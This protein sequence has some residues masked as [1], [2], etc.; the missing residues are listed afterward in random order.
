MESPMFVARSVM[1]PISRQ[2]LRLLVALALG[3]AGFSPSLAV[4]QPAKP[5]TNART[6]QADAAFTRGKD[7]MAAEKFAEA[8]VAFEESQRIDPR[9]PTLM[10]HANCR[11]K[12]AQLATASRLFS[13]VVEQLR[14][15][16]D[17][18]SLALR[19]VSSDRVA[20]LAPRLSYLT[21]KVTGS[22]AG[23][24][25]RR[26]DA[27]LPAAQ[28][29]QA[30]PVD[31]GTYLLT[32]SAPGQQ[33]W[34]ST[35]TVRPEGDKQTV[36]VPAL[37]AEPSSSAPIVEV[38]DP[39]TAS[40]TRKPSLYWMAL[41]VAAGVASVVLGV[42]ALGHYGDA[43]DLHDRDLEARNPD[44]SESPLSEALWYASN[45]EM[46][47][48][49]TWGIA[50]GVTA[51]VGVGLGIGLYVLRHRDAKESSSATARAPTFSPLLQPDRAGGGV[52]G[53]QL[54]GGW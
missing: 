3:V 12:N 50:S 17:P 35:I 27:L 30:V 33:P 18:D 29:N 6:A 22:P 14:N 11:E 43:N 54:T 48:A 37:A 31:G 42:V 45:D 10:N 20:S 52:A 41:P 40:S 49:R 46:A 21:L 53:L 4:A 8:C 23:L 34:T 19:N 36:E 15:A 2:V 32:A 51:T 7:L 25:L 44:G 38:R 5:S 1:S 24:E 9:V 13:E 28:W 16:T 39:V 47:Q 26:G